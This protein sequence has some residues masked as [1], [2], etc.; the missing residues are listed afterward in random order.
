[1]RRRGFLKV[2]IV[3]GAIL[4][5]SGAGV[6]LIPGDR[7]VRPRAQLHVFSEAQFATFVALAARVL[8]RTTADPVTIAHAVDGTL[9]NAPPEVAA[10]LGTALSLLDNALVAL[11]TGRKPVP[12]TQLDEAAQD[13][14]FRAW[15]RS[16]VALLRSAYQGLRQLCLA[17][18]YATPAAAAALGYVPSI[19]KPEPPPITARGPLLVDAAA[20]R[21]QDAVEMPPGSPAPTDGGTP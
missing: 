13:A 4:A 15:G 16:R 1:M 7:S 8:A 5:V 12:F 6:A 19:A 3:G 14:A 18:H 17:A 2:G 20:V 11:L 10:D 9:R 21:A